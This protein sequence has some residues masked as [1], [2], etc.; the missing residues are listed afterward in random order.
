MALLALVGIA[1]AADQSVAGRSDAQAQQNAQGIVLE[2]IVVT[3]T[4][5]KD[6]TPVG[7]EVRVYTRKEIEQS[8]ANTLDEFARKRMLENFPGADATAN[9][10][11]TASSAR[12]NNTNI[13]NA[14]GGTNLNLYNFGGGA[15][16]TLLNGRRVA[17]G[18]LDGAAPDVS[19]IPL[20]AIDHIEVLKGGASAIYG[21]DAVAGVVNI[22]TRKDF[23]GAETSLRYGHATEGGDTEYTASQLLCKRGNSRNLCINYE[24]DKQLGLDARDRADWIPSQGGP[25]SLLPASR[26]N[27]LLVSGTQSLGDSTQI[28][29]DA[30]YSNRDFDLQHSM[31]SLIAQLRSP[32]S[33][34]VRQTGVGGGVDQLLFKDWHLNVDANFSKLE[35]YSDSVSETTSPLAFL[36]QTAEN[37]ANVATDL[38]ETDA[39]IS[40]SLFSLPAGPVK[41]A[42]GTSWRQERFSSTFNETI[43]GFSS[44]F[45]VSPAQRHVGSAFLEIEAPLVHE[46]TWA[47]RLVLSLA[48][49]YDH[50]SD[51]GSTNNPKLGLLWEPITGLDL[52]TSFAT[53][54][55]VPNLEQEY[56]PAVSIATSF[57][58]PSAPLGFQDTLVI[59]GGNP[60]LHAQRA[61]SFTAGF[62]L[63][64]TLVQGLAFS[65]TYL[66]VKFDERISTPPVSCQ[67]FFNDPPLAPFLL[68][69]PP[70]SLVQAYF[71]SPT[72]QGDMLGLGPQAVTAIFDQRSANIASTVESGVDAS[73]N[74]TVS[75][76]HGQLSF[77]LA[78][79]YLLKNEFQA[80]ATVPAVQL[81]NDF[82][83]PPKFRGRGGVAWA[84]SGFTAMVQA[85][86][87]NSYPNSLAVPAQ[88]I[89]AWNTVDLF[90]GYDTREFGPSFLQDVHIGF[91]VQNLFNKKP[92]RADL[93]AI[94]LLPGQQLP[95]YD[96]TNAS[97]V[98]RSY[99]LQISK[100]FH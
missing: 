71:S 52:R 55:Q 5:I 72:F 25:D 44:S 58:D 23:D 17:P 24:F 27:S 82:G 15:T 94:A 65:A 35:Q 86:H 51:F 54:Y 4:H 43:D 39:L 42:V 81:L 16:L 85:N 38:L 67:N 74:Y 78:A 79:T 47:K 36:N 9:S 46:Q 76:P 3:G 20:S 10:L 50:Y 48:G 60:T 92:P 45:A 13:N 68:R 62:D 49:R 83:Q 93:S 73:G 89:S 6:T 31:T 2:Q 66:H 98:R 1:D 80:V 11:S 96:P 32:V 77:M 7:Q 91:N 29:L 53:S 41:A 30:L 99:S 18:G 59:N 37:I 70:P 87:V 8:G 22:I 97:P 34:R 88:K 90:L 28:S 63:R 57:P 69:N 19:L 14:F 56:E 26:R 61:H 21:A 100:R 95:P 64:D 84:S 40:G 33:G 75:V 12:F